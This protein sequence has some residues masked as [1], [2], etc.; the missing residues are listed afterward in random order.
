MGYWPETNHTYLGKSTVTN[1]SPAVSELGRMCIACNNGAASGAVGAA[2]TARLVPIQLSRAYLAKMLF[3]YNGAGVAGT[4]D[5]GIYDRN[6]V[7][8]VTASDTNSGTAITQSGAS[9]IQSVD[10]TDTWLNPGTYFIAH[11]GSTTTTATYFRVNPS[12]TQQRSCGVAMMASALPLPS[13]VTF[14]ATNASSLPI[15]GFSTFSVV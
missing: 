8:I 5:V 10:I 4:V 9:T 11:V 13:T 7:K 6:G 12:A 3:W 14:T 2:N 15:C 1:I